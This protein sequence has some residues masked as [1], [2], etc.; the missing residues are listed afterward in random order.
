M[1]V[2]AP[3]AKLSRRS[4]VLGSLLAVPATRVAW[5]APVVTGIP[6]NRRLQF[7][8]MR[9]D[10]VIGSHVLTF[11]GSEAA[12]TVDIAIKTAVSVGPVTV[13]RYEMQGRET[14]TNGQF[15]GLTTTTNDDGKHRSVSIRRSGDGLFVQ[16]AGF[17]DRTL[18]GHITP[19]THWLLANLSGPMLSPEDGQPIEGAVTPAGRQNIQL[20]DGRAI[21][22]TGYDIAIHTP[23][24]DWYDD[25]K[26][27][28]GLQAKPRDGSTI[29]Y[30]RTA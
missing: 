18:P 2:T 20:A 4:V 14:W 1:S 17:P 21:P 28:A 19:L 10:S 7:Q 30:R 8:I 27:W 23:T 12:L 26:V 6:A 13:F 25:N 3:I 22:A 9:G 15:A 29:E 16:S 11:N 24:R 5:G